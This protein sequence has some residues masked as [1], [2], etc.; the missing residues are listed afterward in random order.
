MK[1][2]NKMYAAPKAEVIEMNMSTSVLMGSNGTTNS[3]QGQGGTVI[4]NSDD[5]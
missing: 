4:D 5:E 3:G 1:K 2:M